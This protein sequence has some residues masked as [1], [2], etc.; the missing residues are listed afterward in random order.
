MKALKKTALLICSLFIL[1]S[2][3]GVWALWIYPSAPLPTTSASGV[4]TSGF[5]YN[6]EEVL[7]DDGAHD[8]NAQ[9]MVGYVI[10]NAK[11][12]LNSKKGDEVFRQIKEK[13]NKQLHSKDKITN[14]QLGHVFED[15]QS[16][17]LE[18]TLLYVSDTQIRL[19]VYMDTQLQ[20]AEDKLNA[21]ETQTVRITTYVTL[22]ERPSASVEGQWEDVGS[23]KGTAV[24][25]DDGSFYV[26][27]PSTWRSATDANQ[28]T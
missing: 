10:H 14:S 1:L 9:E 5:Y 24:V 28:S 21:G 26:I 3:S 17:A 19:Y 7:P 12:G 2:L 20:D 13:P 22:I 8:M 6:T 23:A 25:V 18:F 15:T 16:T 11:A 27:D 4:T